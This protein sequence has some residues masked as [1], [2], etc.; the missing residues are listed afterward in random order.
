M[1]TTQLETREAVVDAIADE[2]DLSP[3]ELRPNVH[4]ADELGLDSLDRLGLAI[5][6]EQR[7]GIEVGDRSVN[8]LK[9]MNDVFQLVPSDV[10]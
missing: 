8:R 10:R 6:I 1:N 2:F 4:L 7:F 5:C 3:E 9:T